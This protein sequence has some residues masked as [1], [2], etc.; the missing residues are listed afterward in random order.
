LPQSGLEDISQLFKIPNL[1]LPNDITSVKNFFD[2]ILKQYHQNAKTYSLEIGTDSLYRYAQGALMNWLEDQ[3]I[4]VAVHLEEKQR[5]VAFP[6]QSNRI[7]QFGFVARTQAGN[8]LEKDGTP[9]FIIVGGN[10]EPETTE[11]YLPTSMET[12]SDQVLVFKYNNIYQSTGLDAGVR[13][14]YPVRIAVGLELNPFATFAQRA[15]DPSAVKKMIFDQLIRIL[16]QAYAEDTDAA[17]A[18]VLAKL[19]VAGPATRSYLVTVDGP[20]S[21]GQREIVPGVS[22]W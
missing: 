2:L 20:G 11:I 9:V 14:V 10:Q 5:D 16:P 7:D 8:I 15:Q 4:T 22:T 6:E 12:E 3:S 18:H 19:L 13:S 1:D 21:E 17:V